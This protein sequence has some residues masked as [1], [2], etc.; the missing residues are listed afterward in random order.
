MRVLFVDNSALINIDNSYYT[1]FKNGDLMMALQKAGHEV[2]TFQ[3]VSTNN[4]I[5]T[6]D[7]LK[8]NIRVLPQFR[9]KNKLWS[10]FIAYYKLLTVVLRCDF[11]YMYYPNT[12]KFILPICWLF[13]KK[14]SVYVRGMIGAN[15]NFSY[16]IYH[17]A[18]FVIQT[19]NFANKGKCRA[20]LPRP[21]I[22]YTEED[23]FLGR[24]YSK[25]IDTLKLLYL[26]RLD[27]EKGLVELLTAVSVL[28]DKGKHV[29]LTIVG[30]GVDGQM[31][32]KIMHEI[33]IDD[34]VTFYG[35]EYDPVKIKDIYTSADVYVLPTYHE[36]FP[37][38]VYEAM[39]F[40]TPVIT[41]MVGGIPD[42]M[43]DGFNCKSIHVK[44]VDSIV[45]A[46]EFII[47]H[48]DSAIIWAKNGF[49]SVREVLRRDSHADTLVKEISK[50]II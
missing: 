48:Y 28:K 22:N 27:R 39:I 24:D 6:F 32:R 7:L 33:G 46:I 29:K 8:H 47:D 35:V 44:S 9:K 23:I 3:F 38:T 5:S 26:G 34:V 17:H 20:L 25:H 16:W 1:H 11:V 41:T 45:D 37:R 40:G 42:V 31:L 13:R 43:I 21:M 12:F 10:Y 19:G 36:G 14:Y 4:S 2:F 18:K 30:E 50:L 49:S 15:S